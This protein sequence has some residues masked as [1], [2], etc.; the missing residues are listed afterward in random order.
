M[1]NKLKKSIKRLGK[2]FMFL[3]I[4]IFVFTSC[5]TAAQ[6][7]TEVIHAGLKETVRLK[8]E[9]DQ[10]I[11]KSLDNIKTPAMNSIRTRLVTKGTPTLEQLAD[12]SKLTPK[13]IE[14]LIITNNEFTRCRKV[15]IENTSKYVP[16]LIPV[17]V[18]FYH[19]QDLIYAD[20]I[21]R[22]ITLGEA[23]RKIF[24]EGEQFEQGI[25]EVLSNLAKE[26]A[27]THREEI[28]KR[29]LALEAAQNALLEW[30]K[31][32]QE[33]VRSQQTINRPVMTNCQRIGNSIY[34]TTY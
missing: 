8:T 16:A 26:L 33:L 22:K 21:Q 23:N 9:C 3:F 25:Y 11:L 15:M 24:T 5:Q 29:E 17:I 19:N 20:M 31:T 2:R 28:S 30:G 32:Q 12:K 27:R 34:C 6:R 7:R 14:A 1:N 13:E 4:I 10:N 18:R